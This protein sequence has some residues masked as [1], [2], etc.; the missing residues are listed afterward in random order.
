MLVSA[1]SELKICPLWICVSA[2]A[3]VPAV[4]KA[5]LAMSIL[6]LPSAYVVVPGFSVVGV[7][8]KAECVMLTVCPLPIA[9][10]ASTCVLAVVLLV[11]AKESNPLSVTL[12]AEPR[13][14]LTVI[15]VPPAKLVL[16]L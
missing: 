6:L 1:G 10:D 16:P 14:P 13:R 4:M 2:P 15:V 3:A 5:L 9:S 8:G 7:N 12:V 11:P